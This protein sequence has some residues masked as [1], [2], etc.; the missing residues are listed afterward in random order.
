M[1]ALCSLLQSLR[2]HI[3]LLSASCSRR[4]GGEYHPASTL[5]VLSFAKADSSV[6]SYFSTE[7]CIIEKNSFNIWES[8]LKMF[9]FVSMMNAEE[10]SGGVDTVTHEQ[11]TI[12]L[13]SNSV[14]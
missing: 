9:A 11:M 2:A 13:I 6:L 4:R 14:N 8:S 1:Q 5:V 3:S 12:A 7:N 10:T